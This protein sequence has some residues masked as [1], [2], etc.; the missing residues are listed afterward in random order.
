MKN[1]YYRLFTEYEIPEN[2]IR[3]AVNCFHAVL[4]K[5]T[6]AVYNKCMKDHPDLW[7]NCPKQTNR[8]YKHIEEV[9]LGENIVLKKE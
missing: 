5:C 2:E 9:N 7:N 8:D 4:Y 3:R 6:D 1:R